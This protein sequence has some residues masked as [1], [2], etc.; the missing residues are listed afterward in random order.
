MSGSVISSDKPVLFVGGNG[1]LCLQS[2]T[3]RGGGC[4]SEHELVPPV[5]A[6]GHEYVAMPYATRR[7]DL[8]PESIPY[9]IVGTVDGTVLTVDP[10]AAAVPASISQ[11]QVVDF[12]ATGAFV[13]SSQDDQ[14]AFWI[15]QEMPGCY[16]TGGSRAGIGLD[17]SYGDCLGDEDDVTMIPP[18]QW[19]TRY[20]FFTDPTYATTNLVLART[21]TGGGFHDVTV[22]CVGAVSGWQPVGT[23]GR[24]EVTNVDL[25]RGNDSVG[26][27]ENGPHV[28]TSDGP[29][30]VVVWGLDSYASYSYPAGGNFKRINNVVVPPVVR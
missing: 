12:E 2:S 1:H 18:D 11:G 13:V 3:S 19:L 22:D 23:G 17:A 16:V 10:P 25:V 5:S 7:A 29:F 24:Y 14:H 28:A 9:R 21:N 27:C 30:A 26:T 20:V 15:A 4:D 6:L 8:Q